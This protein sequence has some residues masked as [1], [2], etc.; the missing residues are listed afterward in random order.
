MDE[1][2]IFYIIAAIIWFLIKRKKKPE[3]S[4]ETRP[5]PPSSASQPQRKPVSFEE[6]LREITE[7]REREQQP[8][9]AGRPQFGNEEEEDLPVRRM[10]EEAEA[11]RMA[12][13]GRNRQFADEESRRVYEESVK[14]AEGF[15]IEFAPD[16]KFGGKKILRSRSQEEGP[17]LGDEIREGLLEGDDA[18]KAVIYAEIFARKY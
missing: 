13:E 1:R 15:D 5:T 17:T 16:E 10:R 9:T 3:E 2:I 18:R 6:L 12:E 4:Q 14:Q 7:Q 8:Q 11:A